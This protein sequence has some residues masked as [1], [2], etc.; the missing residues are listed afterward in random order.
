MQPIAFDEAGRERHFE[1]LEERCAACSMYGGKYQPCIHEQDEKRYQQHFGRPCPRVLLDPDNAI[2]FTIM[3]RQSGEQDALF[4]AWLPLYIDALK[5]PPE[6]RL[7]YIERAMSARAHPDVVAHL[8][9]LAQR[10]A[11]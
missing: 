3:A 10:A 1:S 9:K 6:D 2:P 8:K 5:L 11:K 4:A 7:R